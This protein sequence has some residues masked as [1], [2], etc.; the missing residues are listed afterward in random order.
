MVAYPW[1][2]LLFVVQCGALLDYGRWLCML[3]L[4]FTV[5][6]LWASCC[7]NVYLLLLYFLAY[8][9]L[10]NNAVFIVWNTWWHAR[11]AWQHAR[12]V[13]SSFCVFSPSPALLPRV[14]CWLSVHSFGYLECLLGFLFLFLIFVDVSHA[15]LRTEMRDKLRERM[16]FI[17]SFCDWKPC[18]FSLPAQNCWLKLLCC[19]IHPMMLLLGLFSMVI[20]ILF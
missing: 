5:Q 17:L 6:Y 10:R 12:I 7:F 8:D 13:L 19:L 3:H 4:Y 9:L 2:L 11:T 18:V 1:L 15:W 16:L 20:G 14:L